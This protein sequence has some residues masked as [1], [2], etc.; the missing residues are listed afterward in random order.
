MSVSWMSGRTVADV[1]PLSDDIIKV[2]LGA[3]SEAVTWLMVESKDRALAP[4]GNVEVVSRCVG[5]LL[6]HTLL[7]ILHD[8]FKAAL[9]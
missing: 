7:H 4:A 6:W 3:G 8:M 2:I 1:I 9:V 5:G